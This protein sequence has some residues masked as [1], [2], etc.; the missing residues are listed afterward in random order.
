MEGCRGRSGGSRE[1]LGIPAQCAPT[2][3]VV[4]RAVITWT[5]I[6]WTPPRLVHW[7]GPGRTKLAGRLVVGLVVAIAAAA[8]PGVVA[9]AAGGAA[10]ELTRTEAGVGGGG[11]AGCYAYAEP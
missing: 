1:G 5:A 3:L 11:E 8:A 9:A 10:V 2:M 7:R 4:H 6:S